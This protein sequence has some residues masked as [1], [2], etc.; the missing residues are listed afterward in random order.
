VRHNGQTVRHNGRPPI[1]VSRI[2][3]TDITMIPGQPI[4]MICPDCSAW[5]VLARKMIKPHRMEDRGSGLHNR[6]CSGSGQRIVLDVDV[7][8]WLARQERLMPDALQPET[9]RSAAPF[10]KPLPPAAP[11]I[12][13]VAAAVRE[14]AVALPT[15]AEAK[16]ALLAHRRTCSECKSQL[17]CENSR[18]LDLVYRSRSER[19]QAHRRVERI[20]ADVQVLLRG[21]QWS[22]VL[23]SVDDTDTRRAQTPVGT[24]LRGPIWAP[25]PPAQ[26]LRPAS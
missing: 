5:R 25:T 6:R 20:N 26:T 21:E 12:R 15:A 24:Q 7:T 23:P 18:S 13:E 17:S 22:E 1:R 16:T 9:R 3:C 2:A 10:Y 11:A 4:T 8:T 19:E 14:Q